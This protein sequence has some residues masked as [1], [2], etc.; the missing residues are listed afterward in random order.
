MGAQIHFPKS[1]TFASLSTAMLLAATVNLAIGCQGRNPSS[2]GQNQDNTTPEQFKN[3]SVMTT[4]NVER[5]AAG[6]EVV[7]TCTIFKDGIEIPADDAAS[8][9]SVT[10]PVA[11]TIEI[12]LANNSL[13]PIAL[14]GAHFH[15]FIPTIATR[16][17]IRCFAR[18]GSATG[19]IIAEDTAGVVLFVDAGSVDSVDT[20]VEP[21]LIEAGVMA[22]VSCEIRDAY[23]NLIDPNDAF[24]EDPSDEGSAPASGPSGATLRPKPFL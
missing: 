9:S 3:L 12:T 17:T 13:P 20:A 16:H 1:S 8:S 7:A 19:A 6:T 21:A 10:S 24:I 22:A 18:E 11:S 4:L 5:T 2:P 14:A 15:S 23:G